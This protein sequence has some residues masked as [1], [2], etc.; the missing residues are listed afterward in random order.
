MKKILI[1]TLLISLYPVLIFA[2]KKVKVGAIIYGKPFYASLNGLKEGLKEYGYI[3]NKNIVYF[4][5]NINGNLKKIKPI[6]DKFKKLN[7]NFIFT[8]T[9]FV[10]LKVKS[11]INNYKIPVIFNEVDDP[12]LSGVV[13]SLSKPGGYLTGV[14]HIA[15]KLI[16]K[17]LEIFK[18]AFPEIKRII[19]F[20]NINTKYK[21]ER[22]KMIKLG[23]KLLNLKYVAIPINSKEDLYNKAKKLT[24]N[25]ESDG[26]FWYPDAF[27]TAHPDVYFSLSKKF[28][29]PLMVLDNIF[30]YHGG[31]IGY[32]PDFYCVGKQ[33]AFIAKIILNG[34][35]PA[36]IPVE[37]PEEIQLIINLKEIKKL[38]LFSFFNKKYLNYADKIIR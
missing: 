17:R 29:V 7:V 36:N 31:C 22:L 37:Y 15:A 25:H 23:C 30:I 6:L 8:T 18:D 4:P 33:S 9:T 34:G 13:K 10:A 21:N 5:E 3:E 24:L 11:L 14:S 1:I 38:N 20:Y 28:K 19:F 32:S 26:L 12:V 35:K 2:S 16:P 27:V